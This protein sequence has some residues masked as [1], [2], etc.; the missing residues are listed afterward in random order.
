MNKVG[1]YKSNAE[2]DKKVEGKLVWILPIVQVISYW[3]TLNNE[4]QYA[5]KSIKITYRVYVANVFIRTFDYYGNAKT[6]AE[7]YIKG[8]RNISKK[9]VNKII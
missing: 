8:N 1:H 5:V 9:L 6:F 7:H 3:D 4:Y 2:H